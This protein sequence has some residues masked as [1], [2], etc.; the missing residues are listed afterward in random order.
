MNGASRW[1]DASAA[2]P[3]QAASSASAAALLFRVIGFMGPSCRFFL[4]VVR[5]TD[6]A[7]AGA[8]MTAPG[9]S[10]GAQRGGGAAG[11]VVEARAGL[12]RR[13]RHGQVAGARQAAARHETVE[14]RARVVEPVRGGAV[15]VEFAQ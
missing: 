6:K 15:V 2:P 8:R 12:R 4:V 14:C 5:F 7:G 13:Q 9:L 1:L 11:V 3:G 10:Q